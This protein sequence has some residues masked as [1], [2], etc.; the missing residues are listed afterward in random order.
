MCGGLGLSPLSL[1]LIHAQAFL[2]L[3]LLNPWSSS[4]YFLVP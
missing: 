3:E 2:C 4:D 1:S